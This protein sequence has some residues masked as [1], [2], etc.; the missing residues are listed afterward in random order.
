MKYTRKIRKQKG[1]GIISSIK[2]KTTI[3]GVE[4]P[5]KK[6][7]PKGYSMCDQD[8][9]NSGLCVQNGQEDLCSDPN[10]AFKIGR[11]HV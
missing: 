1:R 9:V 11:A 3:K 7:C 2:S 6:V 4:I 5:Y 10:Y 8:E